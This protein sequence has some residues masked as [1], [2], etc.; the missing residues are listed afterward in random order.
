MGV[1]QVEGLAGAVWAGGLGAGSVCGGL[2]GVAE[3]SNHTASMRLP[4]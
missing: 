3:S 4:V 2:W 1:G